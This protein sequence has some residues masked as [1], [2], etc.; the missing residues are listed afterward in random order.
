MKVFQKIKELRYTILRPVLE[1]S[2]WV[3]PGILLILTAVQIM[4]HA[5]KLGVFF[6]PVL[7]LYGFLLYTAF[8]LTQKKKEKRD[9][10]GIIG[11]ELYFELYPKEKQRWERKL[12]RQAGRA[13]SV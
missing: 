13:Q 4:L 6:L 1:T 7:L 3:W 8:L 9:L 10:R 11:D 5:R 2:V 12:A